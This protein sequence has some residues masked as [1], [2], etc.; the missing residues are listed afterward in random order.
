MN[1]CTLIPWLTDT[2][3]TRGR[4]RSDG[5]PDAC[6]E[7]TWVRGAADARSDVQGSVELADQKPAGVC[8]AVAVM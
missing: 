1:G 4:P 8:D 6:G 7:G 5:R 3:Q 2:T